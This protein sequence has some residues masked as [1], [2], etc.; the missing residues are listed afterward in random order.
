MAQRSR[1]TML[2]GMLFRSMLVM[3]G[4]VPTVTMGDFRMMRRLLMRSSFVVLRGFTMV[5]RRLIVVM[6]SFLVMFVNVFGHFGSPGWSTS[7]ARN[8]S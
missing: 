5:L 7:D 3:L 1:L 8:L 4:G 2:L 6:R